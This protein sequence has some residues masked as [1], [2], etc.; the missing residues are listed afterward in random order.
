MQSSGSVK[1]CECTER[2][3][4]C[5][6]PC[7]KSVRPQPRI[8]TQSPVNAMLRSSITSV[9]HPFVCPGVVRTS[10]KRFPNSIV[11]PCPS[12][13]SAPSA[14]L[15]LLSAI[16]LP[17][18]FLRSQAPVTWSAWTCVSIVHLSQR[19]SSSMRAV[20]RSTWS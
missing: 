2:N 20:S 9:M 1:I 16:R 5:G 18:R 8:S 6:S 13:R 12:R 14:P 3:M 19:S 11:S 4:A 17:A 7:W 15:A 10:R